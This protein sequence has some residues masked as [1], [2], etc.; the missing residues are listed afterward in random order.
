MRTRRSE[1][2]LTLWGSKGNRL[3]QDGTGHHLTQECAGNRLIEEPTELRMHSLCSFS[4]WEKYLAVRVLCWD[5]FLNPYIRTYLF[6]YSL[7]GSSQ[8]T[9]NYLS[10]VSRFA[11]RC[12]PGIIFAK[13]RASRPGGARNY[14]CQVSRF[15]PRGFGITGG[16]FE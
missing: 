9:G 2:A 5:N 15:A 1:D 7:S 3:T 10:Q 6:P 11:D 16:I 13:F 12:S 4:W 8:A 14:F